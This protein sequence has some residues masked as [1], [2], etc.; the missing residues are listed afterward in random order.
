M[1]L[2]KTKIVTA[3]TGSAKARIRT[4]NS[5]SSDTA[6]GPVCLDAPE[7]TLCSG[8]FNPAV[9]A[10]ALKAMRA[11]MRELNLRHRT[12]LPMGEIAWQINPLLRGGSN[13]TDDTRPQL[14]THCS[15]TSIRR[16]WLGRCGSSGALKHTR[17]A[18]VAFCKNCRRKKRV[19]SYTGGLV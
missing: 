1:H 10:S 17:S 8:G 9:S 11:A 2:T 3:R 6:F 7:T 14:C 19:R 16:F 18:R 4:F 12:E 13:T 15:D 5:T